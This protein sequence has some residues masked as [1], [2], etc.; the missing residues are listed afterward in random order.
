MPNPLALNP[1]DLRHSVSIQSASTTQD[2][3]GSPTA[4]WTV[5][6][7]T[8]ASIASTVT[9]TYKESFSDNALSSQS[10]YL[11]T[12]RWP[13]ASIT[14]TPGMRVVFGPNIF[15]IQ[16][17]DNVKMLNRVVRLACIAVTGSSN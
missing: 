17:V 9:A 4:A 11:L 7:A 2:S 16:A 10:T 12:I 8:R 1:G 5:V 14:I 13:G 15:L 3:F 6:L